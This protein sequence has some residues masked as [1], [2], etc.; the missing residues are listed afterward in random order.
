MRRGSVGRGACEQHLGD[1]QLARLEAVARRGHVQLPGAG[2]LGK[3]FTSG[4]A[5]RVLLGR[6]NGSQPAFRRAFA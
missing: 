5:G 2:D 6:A 4:Q 3:L 1:L